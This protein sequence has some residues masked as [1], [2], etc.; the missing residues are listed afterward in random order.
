[1]CITK[2]DTVTRFTLG[3][4]LLLAT[5]VVS[6]ADPTPD[7]I[8]SQFFDTLIK[9]DSGKAVDGFFGT[10]PMFKEKGQQIQL[11]KSQLSG[12][13]QIYGP[14]TAAELIS[15][16]DLSPSLQRR[17]YITKHEFHPLSWEMYFYKG[18][19]GWLS[20]QLVFVDQYQ[21]IGPKK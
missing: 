1:L 5:A 10:N 18:T 11:L 17:V 16:Q 19:S 7:S 4:A 6:A 2:G 8:S 13:L 3:L 14:A 9:G 12:A 20:D 15:K 21:V